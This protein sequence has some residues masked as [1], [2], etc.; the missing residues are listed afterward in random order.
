MGK[1]YLD[2]VTPFIILTMGTMLDCATSACASLLYGTARHKFFAW[3][4]MAEALIYVVLGLLLV[5]SYHF[6][7]VAL[8]WVIPMIVIKVFI[9]P[10]YVCGYLK[11]RY[12]D[13]LFRIFGWSVVKIGIVF[14]LV[15]F[16]VSSHLIGEGLL[17]LFP[18]AAVTSIVALPLSFFW[19]LN[20]EEKKW[21]FNRVGIENLWKKKKR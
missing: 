12:T 9:Q 8:G 20:P 17:G 18:S 4:N 3:C 16:L 11:L 19:V 2:A 13:F 6:V 5:K 14:F 1:D 15:W 7:G 10:H 21:V